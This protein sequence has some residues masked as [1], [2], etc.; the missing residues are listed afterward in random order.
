MYNKSKFN[1]EINSYNWVLDR[2]S[3]AFDSRIIETFLSVNE[4]LF[5]FELR[6]FMASVIVKFFRLFWIE[7]SSECTFCT[8]HVFGSVKVSLNFSWSKIKDFDTDLFV[9][10]S[11]Y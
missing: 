11:D 9:V 10:S 2:L 7:V 3:S 1:L 4:V 6:I 5:S 8:G